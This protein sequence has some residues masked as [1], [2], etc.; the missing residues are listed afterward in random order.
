MGRE[1][2]PGIQNQ[3]VA[4]QEHNRICADHQRR[5]AGN[6]LRR[7]QDIP[8]L[9]ISQQNVSAPRC[10]IRVPGKSGKGGDTSGCL[11]LVG[12]EK[13]VPKKR[14]A[15]ATNQLKERGRKENYYG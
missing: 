11:C 12:M 15:D 9:L 14:V 6:I 10:T 2:P 8:R 4:L 13:K 7:V 1:T 3:A 5:G